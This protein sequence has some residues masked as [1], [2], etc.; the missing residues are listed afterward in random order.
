MAGGVGRR[1]AGGLHGLAGACRGESFQLDSHAGEDF[2]PIAGPRLAKQPHGRIPRAVIALQQPA[3]VGHQRQRH[4]HRHAQR[5]G[6]VGHGRVGGDDQIQVLH[7]RRG[8]DKRSAGFVQRRAQIDQLQLL[9]QGRQLLVAVPLLQAEQPHAGQLGQGRELGQRNRAADVVGVAGIAL[10]GDAHAQTGV[11]RQFLLPMRGALALCGQIRDVG[12]NR[13]HG[14]AENGGQ[15]H[16]RH[17]AIKRRARGIVDRAI[18][19]GH[20]FKQRPQRRRSIPQHHAAETLLHQPRVAD[21]LDAVAQSLLALDQQCAARA[22]F[23]LPAR[24]GKVQTRSAGDA[25]PPLVLGPAVA[26]VSLQQPQ[27]GAVAMCFG[28]VVVATQGRVVAS[29]RLVELVLQFVDRAQVVVGLD[30]FGPATN[31][32]EVV[33]DGFLVL[34]I[35]LQDRGQVEVRFGRG[36]LIAQSRLVAADRRGQIVLQLVDR[37]QVVVGL[38]VVGPGAD[39]RAIAL[40]GVIGA[41]LRLIDD[42]QVE[43]GLGVILIVAQGRDVA[44]DGLLRLF[45]ALQHVAQSVVRRCQIGP[46]FER[47]AIAGRRLI[48]VATAH[49]GCLPSERVLRRRRD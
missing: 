26:K 20:A 11:L 34:A 25:Q 12:R 5:A 48:V 1:R 17:V 42:A 15:A 30:I 6:Q 10:P 18:D 35:L 28:Q 23:A 39:G 38:D 47:F 14:G 9:G 7:H 22:S 13:L 37:A 8:I 24:L 45:L 46:H 43:M 29:E 27:Q 44:V 49:T 2:A 3:P 33:L 41:I 32:R 19:A 21:E 40:G 36:R 31:C 16:H 4:P